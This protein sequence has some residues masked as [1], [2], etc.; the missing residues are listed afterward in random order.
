MKNNAETWRSTETR[1]VLMVSGHCCTRVQKQAA[2]LRSLGW[3][4]DSVSLS[5]PS[6]RSVFDL[7]V[8]ASENKFAKFI[9]DNGAPIIH[10][11]NEPDGLMRIADEGCNG[12]PIVYDCHDLAYYRFG[13]VNADELYAFARADAIVHVSQEHRDVAYSLH[14][15]SSPEALVMSCPSRSIVPQS[16]DVPRDGVVYHGGLSAPGS[17]HFAWRDYSRVE[18]MFED[19]GVPFH[20]YSHETL[21]PYYK[22]FKPWLDYARLMTT[23]KRYRFGFVGM[24]ITEPKW[25]VAVPNKMWEYAA[26]GVVPMIVNAPAAAR[27]FG[28][29]ALVADTVGEAIARMGEEDDLRAKMKPRF[30]EDEIGGTVGLYEALL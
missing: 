12:R 4:V 17:T 7:H 2:A 10:V 14:P 3:R 30:M 13:E 1:H 18:Q 11:H 15:W 6:N 16:P 8:V 24:D 22:G 5:P 28:E 25:Q 20:L 23:L 21:A 29:G 9:R 27:A 19:A 26:A